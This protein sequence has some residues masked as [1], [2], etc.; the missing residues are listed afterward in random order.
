VR[1]SSSPAGLASAAGLAGLA[2]LHLAWAAGSAWPFSSRAELADAVVGTA[3]VPGPAACLAVAA[4]LGSAAALAAGAPSRHPA[5]RESGTCGAVA[6]LAA[7]GAIGLAGQTSLISPGSVSAKFRRLDR[8]VYSPLCLSLA[9]LL[10]WQVRASRPGQDC[11]PD[12]R[13]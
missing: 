13:S 11:G 2:G 4:A 9:A 6:V 1:R 3:E 10:G 8:A 12:P 5:I 7:R